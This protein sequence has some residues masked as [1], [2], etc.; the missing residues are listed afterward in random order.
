MSLRTPLCSAQ[1]L[2]PSVLWLWVGGA[3]L[4][5]PNFRKAGRPLPGSG[6]RLGWGSR[7]EPPRGRA[8]RCRGSRKRQDVGTQHLE[9]ISAYPQPWLVRR[10]NKA[11]EEKPEQE[12]NGAS[13]KRHSCCSARGKGRP[14]QHGGAVGARLLPARGSAS[15]TFSFLFA[16]ASDFFLLFV[17]P[18]LSS[19]LPSLF[20]SPVSAFCMHASHASPL[21]CAIADG[22]QAVFL[23]AHSYHPLLWSSV[24]ATM[25]I[26]LLTDSCLQPTRPEHNNYPNK[27]QRLLLFTR[28]FS[29]FPSSWSTLFKVRLH[30]P[31]EVPELGAELQSVC[32]S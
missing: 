12:Q 10:K 7:A 3:L 22:G 19:F 1:L 15:L 6:C 2:E 13:G 4:L 24:K 14:E 23:L 18:S 9:G 8:G 28:D 30:H 29:S 21:F 25:A 5:H 20:P 17:F 26:G 11:G 31:T 32:S 27:R 16:S